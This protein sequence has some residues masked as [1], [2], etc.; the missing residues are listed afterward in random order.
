MSPINK[1]KLFVIRQGMPSPPHARHRRHRN[2]RAGRPVS[3]PPD[4][5]FGLIRPTAFNLLVARRFDMKKQA[6]T[7]TVTATLR[8]AAQTKLR[9]LRGLRE[10]L[11]EAQKEKIF[12]CLVLNESD[13]PIERKNDPN[14]E[15][16]KASATIR[17]KAAI[18]LIMN[19]FKPDTLIK[20]LED[21]LLYMK[22]DP[23]FVIRK[24]GNST[25]TRTPKPTNHISNE[26]MF[27]F[28]PYYVATDKLSRKVTK[29]AFSLPGASLR[30][31]DIVKFLKL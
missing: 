27:F 6:G 3:I 14:V 16:R 2:E 31:E 4:E 15:N 21:T 8:Q 26:Y 1:P 12:Q 7:D 20:F 28:A 13:F 29:E 11:T 30:E 24:T 10:K 23:A 5:L 25:Q 17:G 19:D 18:F 9:A 22:D